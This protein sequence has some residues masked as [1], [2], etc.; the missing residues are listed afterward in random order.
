M[1]GL[2]LEVGKWISKKDTLG[3]G[4]PYGLLIISS[5]RVYQ[6]YGQQKLALRRR[7]FV[8]MNSR[9]HLMTNNLLE[10]Y[11]HALA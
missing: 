2:A 1:H 9:K 4:L 11:R 6:G 5:S 3:L 8:E 7:F 10:V